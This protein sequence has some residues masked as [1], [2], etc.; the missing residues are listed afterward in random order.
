MFLAGMPTIANMTIVGNPGERG[1][2][3]RRGTGLMLYNSVVA[4]NN[5]CLRIQGESLNQLGRGIVF[6]G[7][8]FGC[9]TVN[10]GDDVPAVQAFLDG[11][12]SV[13]QDGSAPAPVTL[14]AGFDAAGDDV[15]GSDVDSWGDGWTV[16]VE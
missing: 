7:V 1:V 13:T 11:S 2:R 6:S 9:T 4:G 14:P 12:T 15:V 8:G 5:T 16:G 10:E 3:L